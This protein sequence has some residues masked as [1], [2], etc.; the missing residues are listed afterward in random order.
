MREIL[1]HEKK[2]MGPNEFES[3]PEGRKNRAMD[4]CKELV[5]GIREKLWWTVHLGTPSDVFVGG[6]QSPWRGAG[7]PGSIDSAKRAAAIYNKEGLPPTHRPKTIPPLS[8]PPPAFEVPK[9]ANKVYD[10]VGEDVVKGDASVRHWAVNT[11]PTAAEAG[12]TLI[13]SDPSSGP[14][15]PF[16][17]PPPKF[18]V[19]KVAGRVYHDSGGDDGSVRH[20]AVNTLPETLTEGEIQEQTKIDKNIQNCNTM[21][22]EAMT[23]KQRHDRV[24]YLRHKLRHRVTKPA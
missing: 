1:F 2:C 19:A 9:E 14:P 8:L 24:V 11:V 22:E 12:P 6:D 5:R 17:L 20:W 16:F 4:R 7:P 15:P 3:C 21:I 10:A 18:E 13:N 23:E